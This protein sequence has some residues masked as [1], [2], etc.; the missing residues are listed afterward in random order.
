MYALRDYVGEDV[1][2]SALRKLID[3]YARN[4]NSYPTSRNLVETLKAEAGSEHRALIEDLFE[5]ITMYDMKL[6]AAS[7]ERLPDGRFRTTIDI[8]AAKYYADAAGEESGARFD[9]PIDVGLFVR[10]PGD[11]RFTSDDVIWLEKQ[12]V[13]DGEST[14]EVIVER[15]PVFAGI[16]PYNMLVDRNSDDNLLGVNVRGTSAHSGR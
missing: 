8:S 15:M 5:R 3:S 12:R 2:N 10:S 11:R 4:S 6:R 16:D 7:V 13:V 9:I 1:V 14:L